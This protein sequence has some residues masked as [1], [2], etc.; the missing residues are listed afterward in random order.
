MS[1]LVGFLRFPCL[2]IQSWVASSPPERA[3]NAL[4]LLQVSWKPICF[5]EVEGAYGSQQRPAL[6]IRC[7][8]SPWKSTKRWGLGRGRGVRGCVPNQFGCPWR[9]W[10]ANFRSAWGLSSSSDHLSEV[11]CLME[12]FC[13][14]VRAFALLVFTCCSISSEGPKRKPFTSLSFGQVSF[15]VFPPKAL[16]TL[17]HG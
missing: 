14:Q 8:F 5:Q 7:P 2:A 1:W 10:V 6:R 3:T 17:L 16:I 13:T 4:D 12:S 15:G 11:A 9:P